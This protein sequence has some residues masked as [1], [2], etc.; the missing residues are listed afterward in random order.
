MEK[1]LRIKTDICV[2]AFLCTAIIMMFSIGVFAASVPK[3]SGQINS[4][5]GAMLR[6]SASTGSTCLLV[7]SDD[8]RITIHKEVFKSETSAANTKK[9]YYVTAD[10]T[11]GY[12]RADLVD[13]IKYGSVQ[14][15]TT[16]EVNYRK[17]AG[18]GM[19]LAG[20]FAK[21]AKLTV[22]MKANP[23]SSASGSSRTWYKVREGKKYYYLC[24]SWVELINGTARRANASSASQSAST[25]LPEADM[26][27]AEFEKNM[28]DQ[29]FP[30]SY[31]KKLRPLHKKHPNWIF[32]GYK[33]NIA[34]N[35]ALSKQTSGGTSLV[36]A[37]YPASYRDG[38]RQ[39]EKGW[40]KADSKVVAYFMDPRNFLI[41][42]RIFMFE[43]LSYKSKY[44]TTS[45]VRAILSPTKLPGCGFTAG[46]F[47]KAGKANDVSPVFLASRARQETGGGSDAIKGKKIM[48][49]KVYNPFNIG[50]FGGSNPLYNG[51]VFAY[52]KGWTTP[53]KSVEG[54]AKVLAKNYINKGQYTIYYQRFNVRNGEKKA[55]THQYMTNITAPYTEAISTKVSYSKYG[56]L[57]KPIVFEIPIYKG[58]PSSTKLP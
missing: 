27:D 2:I 21:G 50:A 47:V 38:S 20:S 58:M 31:K 52:G 35:T 6:K 39:Y 7:L 30:S 17:G 10:G 28:K 48:G 49:K 18:T 56:I 11:K 14:G 37:S 3:A 45:V 15:K 19:K 42:S 9:W 16:E 57:D 26:S 51:L 41:D 54:G 32:V 33:T 23:V 29:G 1:S 25:E 43:A 12:V 8:T 13:H 55:G 40:Y 44:Q 4:S 53:A 36:S 46:I 5:D 34:W 22:V 24:S